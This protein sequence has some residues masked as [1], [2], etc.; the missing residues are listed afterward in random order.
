M[1]ALE[2][3]E[4]ISRQNLPSITVV[5][6]EDSGQYALLKEKML[7]AI[8]FNPSDL[9]FSYFDMSEQSYTDAALDLESL[10]FF[11]DEKIVIFDYFSDMTTAK[12]SFLDDKELKRFE[13]Y[14][15]NPV[16]TTHLVLFAEGKLDGKRRFVKLLKRE[17]QILEASSLKEAE[18]K[19]YF[20]KK[21]HQLGLAFDSGVFDY[22]VM[23][24]NS[25]FG[26]L[27]K[28]LLF[29]ESYK[30]RGP[31][32]QADIDHAI[33]KTLQDNVFELTQFVLTG[34]IDQARDLAKDLCLQGEDEIKLL[35]IMIGQFRT[36]L[37]VKLLWLQQK[38]ETQIVADLSD[39]LGR[40]VNPYQ[41]KFA[42]RDSRP[43]SQD[44]LER[45]LQILIQA[46]YDIKRGLYDKNY[47][48]DLALL[49]IATLKK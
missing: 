32:T 33:P 3:V 10:P 44:W 43:L 36:F 14:L 49:R 12:K 4:K 26:A 29:L 21:A 20:Q 41:V 28:N 31:I 46:D 13:A 18:L 8:D 37:Q 25:D 5:T 38:T 9:M 34:H 11:A 7:A 47:L 15:A 42:I 17:A 48:F 24:S 2:L 22:L 16:E 45:S 23:K 40:K 27:T 39:F 35:A 19:T 1:I 30:G 6:G